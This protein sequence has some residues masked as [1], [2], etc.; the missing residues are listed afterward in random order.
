MSM[1][2]KSSQIKPILAKIKLEK[3]IKYL[4][5]NPHSKTL[6][7]IIRYSQRAWESE[8]P[9]ETFKL[10]VNVAYCLDTICD[11]TKATYVKNDKEK[12]YWLAISGEL[13]EATVGKKT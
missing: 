11:P 1:N 2:T 13:F 12:K 7:R 9:Q 4:T 5:A 8:D 10:A 3:I 6:K